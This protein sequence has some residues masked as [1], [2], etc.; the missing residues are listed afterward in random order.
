MPRLTLILSDLYLPQDSDGP[1]E[2]ASLHLPN[3]NWLLR[4]ANRREV[5]GDWRT[6]LAL[7]TGAT[8]F[9][10]LPPAQVVAAKFFSRLAN[11]GE[12][13][14]RAWLATPVHLEAR[15]DHVR[16][17]DRGFI[18]LSAA[19]RVELMADF[20]RHF[21][22]DYSLFDLGSRG[23]LLVGNRALQAR[24]VDPTRLLDMDVGDAIPSGKDSGELRRVAAEMEMW[25][26]RTPVN[27]ARDVAGLRR[28]STLWLWGGGAPEPERW[29]EHESARAATRR[30]Q[31]AVHG[32]DPWLAAFAAHIGAG[33]DA[34]P[35]EF[36]KVDHFR[37]AIVELNPMTGDRRESLEYV[38]KHWLGSIRVALTM[39]KLK[40]FDLVANDLRH[41]VGPYGE[42]RFWRRPAPWLSRLWHRRPD[43]KA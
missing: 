27:L 15:I 42:W 18:A 26:H 8:A 16:L 11:A 14:A 7:E 10:R 3:L 20:A 9:A 19:E 36:R 25:L 38:E 28:V 31:I 6:W 5:I 24:S 29:A 30:D 33:L 22:P 21:N 32:D 39:G 41:R 1:P 4:Y 37:P 34:V 17:S 2:R 23:F 43:A 35:M 40:S 13:A 12:L